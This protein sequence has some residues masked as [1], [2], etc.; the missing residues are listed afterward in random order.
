MIERKFIVG[1]IRSSETSKIG[2]FTGALL[3]IQV[4]LF[5]ILHVYLRQKLIFLPTIFNCAMNLHYH[6]A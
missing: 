6:M 4:A 5:I 3:R 2:I 1:E